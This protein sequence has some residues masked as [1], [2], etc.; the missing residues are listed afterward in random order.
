MNKVN[1]IDNNQGLSFSIQRTTS[2]V[3]DGDG[4]HK[5]PDE[6]L[7]L[8]EKITKEDLTKENDLVVTL[9][10]S[11]AIKLAETILK[12]IDQKGH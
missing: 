12:I 9:S 7:F 2:K 1:M 4:T 5:V 10:I 3:L 11:E 8:V 6:I